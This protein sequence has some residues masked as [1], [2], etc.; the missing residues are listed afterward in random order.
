[1]TSRTEAEIMKQVA[2]GREDAP[3]TEGY[4]LEGALRSVAKVARAE[5]RDE[6]QS[7]LE[8]GG[9]LG[10]ESGRKVSKKLRKMYKKD[11]N[12]LAKERVDGMYHTFE[13][14]IRVKPRWVPGQVWKVI[15][16]IVLQH[17]V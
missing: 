17:Y 15:Q 9:L 1:M 7:E 4:T 12:K 6:I 2:L 5:Q 11:L 14:H 16:R 13:E 8:R 10:L 3:A